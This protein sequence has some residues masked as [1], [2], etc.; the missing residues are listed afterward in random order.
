[1]GEAPPP[2][3]FRI[4]FFSAFYPMMSRTG[5][6]STG[7][8]LLLASSPRVAR[9]VIFG[10]T[11]SRMP[12]GVDPGRIELVPVW[13]PDDLWSF[14]RTAWV[15][16][17]AAGRLDG[18][19][20]SISVKCFGRHSLT[21]A[22][23]LLLPVLLR[24]LT[25]KPVVVFV[26]NFVET[27]EI[28]RLG[29]SPSAPTLWAAGFLERLL[30]RSTTTV[31][32]LASLQRDIQEAL[33]GEVR[34]IPMR[35]L[36]V[37]HPWISGHGRAASGGT[38]DPR[39][40]LRVF[41]I[42]FWGP[43]KDLRGALTVLREIRAGGFPLDVTIAGEA[44]PD[45]PGS[46][47]ELDDLRRTMPSEGFRFVGFVPNE[48]LRPLLDQQD[49]VLIP[50]NASGGYSG[51]LNLATG[52]EL[53]VIAYDL[54]ELR[55]NAALLGVRPTFVPRRDVGRIRD[56]LERIRGLP[57]RVRGR[58]SLDGERGIQAARDGVEQLIA[59][60]VGEAPRA[61]EPPGP[62][63]EAEPPRDGTRPEPRSSA[64]TEG[65]PDVP[66]RPSP[67]AVTPA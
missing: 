65:G 36:E 42:G 45:F 66:M 46:V 38:L 53:P 63:K 13:R 15:M 67:T 22:A 6:G 48:R 30:I 12:P 34:F 29:Y 14:V 23:G 47:A 50:Y 5:G 11:G 56:A 49:V 27:Q 25:G 37:Y 19:L 32:G 2:R 64:P 1:M 18:F 8:A 59:L 58:S 60:V 41:L 57:A 62:T 52:F 21:N 35:F 10:P 16:G 26:H 7:M 39:E 61:A 28:E 17:R 31:V 44:H 3:A 33:G 51:V 4:G 20:F 43:Q 40:P 9:A 54:P 24:R 55:E